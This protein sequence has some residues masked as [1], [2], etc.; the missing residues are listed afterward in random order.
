[1][2]GAWLSTPQYGYSGYWNVDTISTRGS[3][4]KMSSVPLP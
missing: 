3:P 4:W 2:F 1:M